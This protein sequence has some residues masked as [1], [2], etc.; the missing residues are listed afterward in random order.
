MSDAAGVA[1]A[2][3]AH[4]LRAFVL[5]EVHARPFHAVEAPLRILHFA[6]L[7]DAV[8]TSAARSSL[9]EYCRSRGA[10]PPHEGDKHFRV[11]LG[12]A[13][14]RWENHAEFSTYTWEFGAAGYAPFDPPSSILA[15]AMSAL[16]QPGPHLV[17]VDLHLLSGGDAAALETLFDPA[18]LTASTVDGAAAVVATDFRPDPGG[19]VRIL[20]RDIRL[21]P[22]RAGALVQ[23]LLEIETYRL[24][25][26][27]GL[28]EAQRLMPR[29]QA[30]EARVS[31]VASQMTRTS[32][33]DGDHALLAELMSMLADL[34]AQSAPWNF[35]YGAT[36]AYERI[37]Q[38]R[39]GA[40]GETAHDGWP[41]IAAFL[42]RRLAP[43]MRTAEMLEARQSD[44]ARKLVRA[45]NLLRTRVDVEIERQNRDV[46]RSMNERTRLQLRLQQT[47]EGLSVA[48][49]S[50]YVVGLAAYVIKGLKEGALIA[51]D[52]GL[53]TAAFVPIAVLSV[54]FVV[55]R[56]R[57][58][59]IDEN[60]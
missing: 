47:V 35:R 29:V 24:L 22:S 23:R 7:T 55:R 13:V 11:A 28:P 59:H 20:L 39:L 2:L 57:G 41:T 53:A 16:P 44:L 25:A 15:A 10:Q 32:G 5:G 9:V 51:I 14:L 40:I 1:N 6:F 8:Q 60:P 21:T 52:P 33:L 4:P 30:I 45:A 48:A 26:L 18:S 12:G 38:Q 31:E 27:L 56:I 36:R 34:E 19:F 50:Y 42:S 37:V 58:S 46:L 17:S 49:I 3:S 54:A 43:A